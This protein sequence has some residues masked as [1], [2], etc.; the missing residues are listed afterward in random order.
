M[1][2]NKKIHLNDWYMKTDPPIWITADFECRN[3]P[4]DDPWKNVVYKQ[5]SGRRLK[6]STKPYSEN[7]KLEKNGS[8]KCLGGNCNEWLVN[9]MLE[10]KTYM[11]HYFE[12]KIE[13]KSN[14]KPKS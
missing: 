14:T 8:N 4:V 13:L 2:T 7:L 5:T 1:D 3:K 9:E 12:Y 10:K 11:K 6:H